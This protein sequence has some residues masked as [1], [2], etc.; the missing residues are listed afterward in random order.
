[1]RLRAALPRLWAPLFICTSMS[2]LLAPSLHLKEPLL[3]ISQ[4]EAFGQPYGWLFRSFDIIAGLLLVAGIRQFV[5]RQENPYRGALYT[6]AILAIIDAVFA[7]GTAPGWQAISGRIHGIESII[8]VGMVVFVTLID[9]WRRRSVPTIWFL[10]TQT[11]CLALALVFLDQR[12]ILALLQYIYQIATVSWLAWFV[13]SFAAPV[14]WSESARRRWLQLFGYA[15]ASLGVALIVTVALPA[16]HFGRFFHGFERDYGFIGQHSVAAGVLLLYLARHVG[17][18][19]RRAAVCIGGLLGFQLVLYSIVRPTPSMLFISLIAYGLLWCGI[20]AF[21]RNVRPLKVSGRISDAAVVIAGTVLAIVLCFAAIRQANGQ[22]QVERI[23]S[24]AIHGNKTV[25]VRHLP[26]PEEITEHSA[27]YVRRVGS[28]LIVATTL[29]L[30]WSLFRPVAPPKH[31]PAKDEQALARSLLEQWSH[32]SEDYFKLWPEDKQYFF[33]KARTAF[34]AYKVSG[35]TA[36]ALADPIGPLRTHKPIITAFQNFCRQQ[37]LSVCFLMIEH[38][39]VEKYRAGFKIMKIG[40]SAIIDCKE[41]ATKTVK[42]KWWRWQHNRAQRAGYTYALSR[43]PHSTALLAETAQL[44]N[45]W[46][47]RAGHTEQTFALGYYDTNYVQQCSLH[48]LREPGG[49]LIAF[50]NQLPTFND[51]R[52]ATV[53]LIRFNPEADGAM[54]TLVMYIILELAA[55]GQERFDL[56]FVPLAKVDTPIAQLARTIS[57]RRFS[58]DGLQQFKGKFKPQWQPNYV[59]YQGDLLSLGVMITQ[60]ESLMSPK[61]Q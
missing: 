48:L 59:A 41:F 37:G 7:S 35:G 10:V 5:R 13:R 9:I 34:I 31:G 52:Q 11:A 15:S 22:Q 55:S 16:H 20:A 4:Y 60:L 57:T 45:L 2:W 27:A 8:S 39:K 61:K 23:I 30:L 3:L 19:Q 28:T 43:P 32:S 56:G 24:R 51:N 46:L 40:S 33:N 42:S 21:D 12:S 6:I 49:Q 14:Q 18:G 44:S 17:Q 53:D 58:I 25:H 1:S 26:V 36:F 50:A 54:P 47:E 38:N 29:T